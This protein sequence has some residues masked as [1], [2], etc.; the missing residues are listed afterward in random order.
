MADRADNLESEGR[1]T[2]EISLDEVPPS[3]IL[4]VH[5]DRLW[6]PNYQRVPVRITIDATDEDS[7]LAGITIRAEDE[8]DKHEPA[9]EPMVFA[10]EPSAYVEI[11]VELIASRMGSDKNGRQYRI[12]AEVTDMAGNS[13]VAMA[14]VMVPHDQGKVMER[15]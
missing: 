8:Y 6:P 12:I 4:A 2:F 3:L 11:V 7:G 9:I 10:G 1:A 5:P 13:A 14:V 15:R